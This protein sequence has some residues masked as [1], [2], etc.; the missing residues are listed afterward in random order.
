MKRYSV[1]AGLLALFAVSAVVFGIGGAQA[2]FFSKLV[3]EAGEVGTKSAKHGIDA[4]DDAGRLVKTLPEKPNT[5]AVGAHAT[6]EGHWTFVSRNGETFTAANADE[7]ARMADN[8]APDVSGAGRRLELHISEETIFNRRALLKDLPEDAELFI[9]SG[10][11]SFPIGRRPTS[12]SQPI[13]AAVRPNVVVN[14]TG[15]KGFREAVWQLNRP[16]NSSDIR[17]FSFQP[18]GA[19]RLSATPRFDAKTKNAMVDSIDPW[20]LKTALKS[21]RG[22]TVVVTGRVEDGVLYFKPS[23]GGGEQKIAVSA[24]TTAASKNDVNL[25]VLQAAATQPG[26]RNWF[27]QKV[28]VEGLD[29]AVKRATFADFINALG[30]GRGQFQVTAKATSRERVVLDVLPDGKASQPI[31]GTVGKWI[32]GV[33]SEITGNVMTSA[34]NV[35][36]NSREQQTEFDRRIFPWLPSFVHIAYL[37]LM[38]VG[39]IGFGFIVKWWGFVWPK[40]D[41]KDYASMFGY[42]AARV[43]RILVLVFVFWPVVALPAALCAIL[44]NVIGIILL[45]FRALG[46]VFRKLRSS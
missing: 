3:R 1:I 20:K 22:Q 30:A 25:V 42:N 12:S 26:G 32:E 38:V 16:L 19:D 27:W 18:G 7:L 11:E 41:A 43:A 46:W 44:D 2:G 17:I 14:L 45:P 5:V 31:S 8:L 23:G 29:Q 39:V 21:I 6:P 9:V 4:L 24:L 13:R 34:I 37:V 35:H 33:V 28:G 40:E 15:A 36:A 10:R